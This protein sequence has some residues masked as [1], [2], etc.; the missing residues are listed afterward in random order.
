MILREVQHLFYICSLIMPTIR[1]VDVLL[2]KITMPYDGQYHVCEFFISHR[3]LAHMKTAHT[4][5]SP[6][7]SLTQTFT[8]SATRTVCIFFLESQDTSFVLFTTPSTP[9]LSSQG[10]LVC[11][12]QRTSLQGY[13]V[14]VSMC[15]C[16]ALFLS[17]LWPR[18]IQYS[19]FRSVSFK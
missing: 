17:N 9:V 18:D 19:A 16:L 4:H 14:C 6:S 8:H 5:I 10:Y 3:H 7:P 15:V 12:C 1:K 11:F 2:I 13:T